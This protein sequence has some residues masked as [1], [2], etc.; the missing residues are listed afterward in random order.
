M[1][2]RHFDVMSLKICYDGCGVAACVHACSHTCTCTH[3]L[4]TNTR[5][6]MHTHFHTHAH[7]HTHFCLRVYISFDRYTGGRNIRANERPLLPP[8]ICPAQVPYVFLAFSVLPSRILLMFSLSFQHFHF[9]RSPHFSLILS[10]SCFR[11]CCCR[12]Y[13]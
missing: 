4:T 6:H 10:S 12:C 11:Y 2:Q 1:C 13:L 3:S 7:T 9:Y 8:T 5:T